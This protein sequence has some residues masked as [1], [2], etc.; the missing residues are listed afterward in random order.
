MGRIFVGGNNNVNT[1]LL[2]VGVGHFS[3]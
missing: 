3:E 2:I 1:V